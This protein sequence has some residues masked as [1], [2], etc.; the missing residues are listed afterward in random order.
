MTVTNSACL[1]R[2]TIVEGSTTFVQVPPTTNVV[3]AQTTSEVVYTGIPSTDVH[4]VTPTSSTVEVQTETQVVV[5]N[6]VLET[7]T[8]VAEVPDDPLSTVTDKTTQTIDINVCPGT[9]CTSQPVTDVF[10]PQVSTTEV[11]V[12][13]EVPATTTHSNTLSTITSYT[14]VT[15][16]TEVEV[17]NTPSS[18]GSSQVPPTSTPTASQGA[19]LE[20]F[21]RLVVMVIGLVAFIHFVK[22]PIRLPPSS[23]L[24]TSH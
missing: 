11:P 17:V 3:V 1:S 4:V 20:V 8:P 14:D 23:F 12:V 10:V 5:L 7:H 13:P 18:T 21:G 9:G 6:S 19:R 2:E 22:S 16:S 15:T 24:A